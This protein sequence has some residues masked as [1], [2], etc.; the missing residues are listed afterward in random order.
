VIGVRDLPDFHEMADHLYERLAN[1]RCVRLDTGHVSNLQD[2]DAF[3]TALQ[4][5]L[6]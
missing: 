1:T 5:F 6:S 4:D 3:S 2:P